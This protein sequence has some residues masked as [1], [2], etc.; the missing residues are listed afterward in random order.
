MRSMPPQ[1]MSIGGA[2]SSRSAI[3]EH[4]RCQPGRPGGWTSFHVG[5]PG[6][7]AFHST[8]SRAFSLEYSSE[9][10]RDFVLWKATQPGEP[11]WNEV[12]PPGRPGWHLECSAMALRLL[13]APPIDIHC[14]G[15]DLMFPHHENEI[16][17][18]EGATRKQ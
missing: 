14:G 4:S 17:Q 15:I 13:G 16:A 10:A 2:P 9:N 6:C 1:W 12:Q 5:S 7:V 18:S 3:A 8:K 11:T